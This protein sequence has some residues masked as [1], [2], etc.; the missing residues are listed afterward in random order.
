MARK[1]CHASVRAAVGEAFTDDQI[2]DILERLAKKRA[3]LAADD[4][5]ASNAEALDAAARELT[6]DEVFGAL[7]ERRMAAAAVK[8]KKARGERLAGLPGD[9]ADRLR[10]YNVG[11]EKQGLFANASVDAEGRAR[12]VALWG[13]V[14]RGLA[15][16]EGLAERLVSNV[17]GRAD[18]DF[19]RKVARELSRLNGAE[20]EPT[21]DAMAV[22]AAQVFVDALE[23]ARLQQNQQG[24]WIGKITG[25]M[26]RQHH[27]RLRVQ[28]GF[29]R[30]VRHMAETKGDLRVASKIAARKAFRSWRDKIHP[31]LDARTFKGVDPE[32]LAGDGW[33]GLDTDAEFQAWL[34]RHQRGQA[35][36]SAAEALH[37]AGAIDTP[38]LE[39]AF[40]YRVWSDI[41][42]G[43]HEVMR[44]AS[45]LGEF[46]PPA[47]KARAVSRSRV[48]HF[49]DADA[50]MDYA[51]AFGAPGGL[52][53]SIMRDLDRA[54]RNAALMA[55]WGPSPEAAFNNEVARLH[56]E[57]VE[58]GDT[59]AADRLNAPLRRSEFDEL[60][61]ANN[62]PGNLRFAIVGRTIRV[63]ESIT[64][65]GG[66]VLSALG[67]S[68]LASQ[69]FVRAGG[70]HIEGYEAV[71][72]GV[73]RLQS[74]T[75]KAVADALDVGAR[76]A[77]AHLSSR[78]AA[79][80]GFS[81]WAAY[82]Q[83]LFYK[84][85]LF[86]GWMD[87]LRS[88]AAEGLS[89]IWGRQA[90]RTFDALEIGTRETMERYG[91]NA[92]AWELLRSG[93]LEASDGRRYLTA[94]AVDTVS[95]AD[96]LEWAG[97]TARAGSDAV[98]R[99]AA[100]AAARAD[101]RVRFQTMVS[102]LLDDV[103]TEARARE[104]VGLLR[105]TKPGTI[106]G[107]FLRTFTQFWSFSQAVI[108]RHLAP[109]AR[110]Y[111]GRQP[112]ALLA[113]LIV[114]STAMG[115]LSLQAKE[116]VKGRKPRPIF[117]ED[118]EFLGGQLFLASM[119]QG[120]GL[121]LYGDFLFGESNRA[122]MTA[123]ISAF[124]GPAVGDAERLYQIVNKLAY[125]SPEQ[126]S[127][128]GGDL[129]RWGVGQVP[130]ANVWYTRL[131][132]DYLVLWRLQEAISPGYLTRYEARVRD[133]Q[134]TEYWVSPSETVS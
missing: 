126:R 54:G 84:V 24:A 117:G 61:G 15:K 57:A 130:F 17:L 6:R 106:E 33:I 34:R 110:G 66:V 44:G 112:V 1:P 98:D 101:L 120:G 20:A 36:V 80:D 5:L 68:S 124:A 125:G 132:L 115:Y 14:E 23:A 114:A 85:N 123:S 58:V 75:G 100:A 128:V 77:A 11:T 86:E 60:T 64:K 38:S 48:L 8:A 3:A 47:G 19:E 27:D 41:V 119:L 39:E 109:S 52:Y 25:Y 43:K 49:R 83:R 22:A 50:W 65:L 45:D 127:N 82:A 93:A 96:L 70:T 31:L 59:P 12:S 111:A 129:L 32:D 81:G 72:K 55:R 99:E 63:W 118:G 89:A 42:A 51:D 13:M 113:H 9:A 73:T 40:L 71:F 76:S 67:D 62:A 104:R 133:R 92:G 79:A 53:A 7:I 131:A 102:G 2:D 18:K 21:G 116:M 87:G 69:T 74:E 90:D 35:K 88:G 56:A 16:H 105:G 122:G 103:V 121:G 97:Y 95:D 29:W 37:R 26:G 108:G 30:E 107:E 134:G 91:L 46:R 78:F 94:E 28:G 10:A 4:P